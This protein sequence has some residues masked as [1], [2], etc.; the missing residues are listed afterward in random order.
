M[1]RSEPREEGVRAARSFRMSA[2]GWWSTRAT[3]ASSLRYG[4][5]VGMPIDLVELGEEEFQEL[6]KQLLEAEG[7]RLARDSIAFDFQGLDNLGKVIAVECKRARADIGAL[8]R[9]AALELDQ[10]RKV[11]GADRALLIVPVHVPRAKAAVLGAEITLLDKTDLDRLMIA[12]P[13]IAMQF[14]KL[15]DVRKQTFASGPTA[16]TMADQRAATLKQRLMRLT[17]G[18][19][20]YR[21]F[22]DLGVEI[23]NFAFQG[24]LGAPR[25][26]SR[27]DDGLDRRDAVYPIVNPGS[28]FS[29]I[30]IACRSMFVVV[31]FKNNSDPVGQKDVES[32]QQY[33]YSGAMRTFGFLVTRS[34]PGTQA[35]IARR[36]A[37]LEF[38]KLIMFLDDA[39]LN[40]LIDYAATSQPSEAL[41]ELQLLEFF[42]T[43][44]P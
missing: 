16:E 12:H 38:S 9:W 19:D 42:A 44:T 7:Y 23:L 8:L 6:C 32:L 30:R 13:I 10:Y 17:S 18:R 33:L 31:E 39:F 41:I 5:A 2:A 29:L 24:I 3:L 27:S 35:V 25:V 36:R 21:E 1:R 20:Y 22:E 28:C 34:K 11:A 14:A 37:W 43:L 4:D 40:D 15:V 26:Q